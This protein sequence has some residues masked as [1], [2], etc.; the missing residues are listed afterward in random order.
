LLCVFSHD[1]ERVIALHPGCIQG[2]KASDEE[3]VWTLVTPEQKIQIVRQLGSSEL[4]AN[5]ADLRRLIASFR[6]V[7][8]QRGVRKR[9]DD[10]LA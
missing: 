10:V 6:W 5:S 8:Q 9:G 2:R 1:V 3:V 7:N 4:T